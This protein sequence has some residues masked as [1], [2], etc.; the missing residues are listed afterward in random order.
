MQ[1]T[2]NVQKKL[3]VILSQSTIYIHGNPAKGLIKLE[4]LQV[5]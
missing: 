5:L 2:V 1:M 4:G 3:N